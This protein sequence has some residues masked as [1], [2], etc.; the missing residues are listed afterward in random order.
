MLELPLRKRGA[1]THI[2][3]S[4]HRIPGFSGDGYV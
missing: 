2:A 1:G 4:D 3:E